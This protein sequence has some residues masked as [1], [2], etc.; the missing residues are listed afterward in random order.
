MQTVDYK[1]PGYING[2]VRRFWQVCVCVFSHSFTKTEEIKTF[3]PPQNISY[4]EKVKMISNS[5]QGQVST[6]STPSWMLPVG[7]G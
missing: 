7:V 2:Y 6:Q 1:M 4:L 3:L 5:A